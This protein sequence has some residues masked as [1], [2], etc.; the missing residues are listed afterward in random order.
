MTLSRR[1]SCIFGDVPAHAGQPSTSEGYS[2]GPP[3]HLPYGPPSWSIESVRLDCVAHHFLIKG[4]GGRADQRLRHSSRPAPAR[5]VIQR[6]GHGMRV[7]TRVSLARHGVSLWP[8][9]HRG[10]GRDALVQLAEVR[11]GHTVLRSSSPKS[12]PKTTP[13]TTTDWNVTAVAKSRSGRRLA[14]EQDEGQRDQSGS[15]V[16]LARPDH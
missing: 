13:T 7:R 12:P 10:Q 14:V 16:D 11:I 15:L 3:R 5:V 8:T 1:G 4:V 9:D 2:T 6:L